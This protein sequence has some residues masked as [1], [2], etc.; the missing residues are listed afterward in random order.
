MI[1]AEWWKAVE[2][3]DAGSRVKRKFPVAWESARHILLQRSRALFS[4]S[5][6]IP[7]HFNK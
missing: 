5:F 4:G 2:A 6:F 3:V 7:L 1:H